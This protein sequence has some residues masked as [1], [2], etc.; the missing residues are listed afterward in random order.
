MKYLL[1]YSRLVIIVAIVFYG[2]TKSD[3]YLSD[4]YIRITD[5]GQG[6]GTTSWTANQKYLIEGKVYVNDGQTLTIEAGTVIHAKT[7]QGENASA[8]IVARGGKIMANGTKEQPIIFTVEGD[9]LEGSVPLET[10]GLWGGV[11]ILGNAP[12]NTEENENQIEGIPVGEPRAT[13]GGPDTEDNSGIFRYVSIRHSGTRLSPDNEINGL[14]LGGVGNKTI[15]EYIE[16]ISSRDD[17]I[18]IFGGTVNPRYMVCAFCGDDAFDFDLGYTGNVQFIVG[19][20]SETIGDLLIELS[21]QKGFPQT[22]PTIANGTF[23]GRGAGENGQ[24]VRFDNSAAG[25]IINSIF[26][27][28]REGVKIEYSGDQLDSYQQYLSGWLQ[29]NN[30]VFYNISDNNSTSVFEVYTK[31]GLDIRN[32]NTSFSQHFQDGLNEIT[33]AGLTSSPWKLE[34]NEAIHQN[35]APTK[36]GIEEVSFKGAISPLNNWLLGWT[37]LDQAGL[38]D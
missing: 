15:V 25:T 23:I 30:N 1:R 37:L 11:I 22:R 19:L 20:E 33:D 6:T 18:E 28:S 35:L 32:E 38:L 16:V 4:G 9:D 27:E 2:C 36:N 34:P 10:S 24:I 5:D 3:Y 14:T 13:Y 8:L 26:V 29:L 31:T 17:G 21:D 7:G 12:V